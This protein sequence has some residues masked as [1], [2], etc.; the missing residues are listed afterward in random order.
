MKILNETE[1]DNS[2]YEV[3]FEMKNDEK[4]EIREIQE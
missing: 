3:K 4:N 2:F 1:G